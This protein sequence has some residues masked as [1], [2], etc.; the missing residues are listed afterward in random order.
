MLA[1]LADAGQGLQPSLYHAPVEGQRDFVEKGHVAPGPQRRLAVDGI[2]HLGPGHALGEAGHGGEQ[3][4][5]L[6]LDICSR[7]LVRACAAQDVFA[8]LGHIAEIAALEALQARGVPAAQQQ[9]PAADAEGLCEVVFLD[10]KAVV[11]EVQLL[12]HGP[13]LGVI[14]RQI[15]DRLLR[16]RRFRRGHGRGLC[17]ALRR[18]LGGAGGQEQQRQNEREQAFHISALLF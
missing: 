14:M 13:R 3:R 17:A 16:R 4:A 11:R 2:E 18:G 8:A 15:M 12:G 9:R 6:L 1:Q 7:A 10:L 5:A